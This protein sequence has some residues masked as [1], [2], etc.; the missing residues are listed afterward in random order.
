MGV[1]ILTGCVPLIIRKLLRTAAFHQLNCEKEKIKSSLEQRDGPKYT[2]WGEGACA[3]GN[4]RASCSL[5]R[6]KDEGLI[7]ALSNSNFSN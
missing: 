7:A 5:Q 4:V 1:V 2:S 3:R 6:G